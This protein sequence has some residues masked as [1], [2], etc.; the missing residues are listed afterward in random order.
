MSYNVGSRNLSFNLFDISVERERE[1]EGK[2]SLEFQLVSTPGFF[3]SV[4]AGAAGAGRR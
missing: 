2:I 1:R 3:G 4:D